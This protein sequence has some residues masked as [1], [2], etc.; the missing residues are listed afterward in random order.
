MTKTHVIKVFGPP[1]TGKTTFL[2]N[3][4]KEALRSGT[5]PDDI[6][7]F[8]FTNKAT[9][10]A[11]DRLSKEFPKLNID[12]DFPGFRTLHSLAYQS[13]PSKLKIMS[14]EEAL[15]FDDSFYIEKVYMKENDP[16]SLV[17]RAKQ[18]VVD[19]AATARARLINFKRYLE[20]CPA[21][22]RYRLNKWLGYQSKDCLR[23]FNHEDLN[24]LIGYNEKYE[25]YKIR[26]GVIDYTSILEECIKNESSIPSYELLIIDESQDL[27]LLQWMLAKILIKK[28][29]KVFIAGDDD[30]AI[31]ESFGADAQEFL[32]I[33]GEEY[34]LKQSY[35]IPQEI[36]KYIFSDSGII[37]R[38]N[39]KYNRKDKS[40]LPNN[41]RSGLIKNLINPKELVNEI[42][43]NANDWLIIAPT[44]NSLKKISLLLSENEIS[45]FLSNKLVHSNTQEIP[46]ILPTVKLM[47]IWG[48]KGGESNNVV[49][50]KGDYVDDNMIKDDLRLEYVAITRTKENFYTCQME[51][52]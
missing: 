36:H 28:A 43:N 32:K 3:Q 11:K 45:H 40:W 10:E 52:R 34:P 38:L 12:V 15:D 44:H 13:L 24:K 39:K 16:T 47:T 4:V 19:A 18:I 6:G 17:L 9:E 37:N 41:S 21:S 8:S 31:C 48:A 22:E 51:K 26:I 29:V 23:E 33:P 49:L 42:K 25:E 1:G 46:T 14:E 30:Q 7:Y 5:K 20:S 27:S 2:I 50:L 35:R